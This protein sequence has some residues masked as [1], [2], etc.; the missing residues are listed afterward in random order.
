[1]DFIT[2]PVNGVECDP[3][4]YRPISVLPVLSRVVERH[5]HIL[6]TFLCDNNL[7]FLR[8]SGFRKNLRT[9]TAL[10]RIIDDLFNLDKDRVSGVVLIDYCK[11]FYIVDHELLLKKLEAYGI[12]NTELKW[13]RSY[14]NGRKQVV[15]LSE[16]ES[17]KAPMK[18][19]IPQGSILGPLFFILFNNDP[20]LHVSSQ[21]HLYA[22]DYL[23]LNFH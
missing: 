14:L 23:N 3:C 21:V 17:S 1:M 10:I 16:K 20:P 22:N 19:G 12:V 18:H 13:C 15:H 8:Q 11:V 2:R 9:E 7:I 6:C 5:V 4:N